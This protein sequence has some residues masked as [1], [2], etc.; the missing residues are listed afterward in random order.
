VSRCTCAAES[1]LQCAAPSARTCARIPSG[2][3]WLPDKSDKLRHLF[4]THLTILYSRHF[5]VDVLVDDAIKTARNA[6]LRS[7]LAPFVEAHMQVSG[8]CAQFNCV[9][10]RRAKSCNSLC[11]NRCSRMSHS[12]QNFNSSCTYRIDSAILD[13]RPASGNVQVLHNILFYCVCPIQFF[14]TDDFIGN[15]FAAR[16]HASCPLQNVILLLIFVQFCFLFIGSFFVSEYTERVRP[17]QCRLE[18][19]AAGHGATAVQRRLAYVD[20]VCC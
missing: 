10:V 11:I 20:A 4:L 14:F 7:E 9:L 12:S 13:Y 5:E 19:C 1:C 8:R 2:A 15:K 16:Q 6:A 17:Y 18:A 3:S